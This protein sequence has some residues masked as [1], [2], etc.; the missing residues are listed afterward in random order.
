[1]LGIIRYQKQKTEIV[2]RDSDL[3]S[4]VIFM[5]NW[6]RL[7][8]STLSN[9]FYSETISRKLKS[10]LGVRRVMIE[11]IFSF[12]VCQTGNR[13]GF[14]FSQF[15]C[16]V[17]LLF[18]NSI[19]VFFRR[20]TDSHNRLANTNTLKCA[21]EHELITGLDRETRLNTFHT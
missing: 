3:H 11:L 13:L 17:Y 15:F 6:L 21:Q 2:T 1:M 9:E 10:I 7:Y 19:T 16:F 4:P 5:G 8:C 12:F 18:I 14:R 20:H